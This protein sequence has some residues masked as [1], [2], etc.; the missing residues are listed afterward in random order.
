[1]ATWSEHSLARLKSP[2][3]LK[4]R[5]RLREALAGLGFPLR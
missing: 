3:E 2:E 4:G 1:V 5:H